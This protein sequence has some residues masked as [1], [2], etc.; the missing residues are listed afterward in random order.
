VERLEKEGLFRPEHKVPLPRYPRRIAVVTSPTG[1]ALRDIIRVIRRRW[2]PAEIYVMP[3]R[4]QGEGAAQEIAAAVRRVN[5]AR[6]DMDL[7]IVARGGGS[8][9]DL[10][11]FNEEAVARAIYDSRLPV[12]SGVGHEVDVTISDLVADLRAATPT[13]AAEKAVPDVREA[14]RS[15]NHLAR[16]IAARLLH[17][18]RNARQRLD[19]LAGRPAMRRP[20]ALLKERAQRLDELLE[21][22]HVRTDHWLQLCREALRGS[23]GRLEALSPLKVLQRG[24]SIT[25]GPDG[26]VLHSP[27]QVHAGD[28]IRSRIHRGEIRS[29]VVSARGAADALSQTLDEGE[30]GNGR[31]PAQQ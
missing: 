4:V 30:A 3:V 16:R 26:A 23:E 17:Q 15:L 7:L 11:A 12:I 31:R 2:P 21:A 24:Y 6:P 1:A 28:D 14:S 10:W 29:T 19:A 27:D 9:E 20:D 25:M 18:A 5:E 22:M 8:I 13:E